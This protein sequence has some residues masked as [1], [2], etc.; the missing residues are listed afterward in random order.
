[1]MGCAGGAPPAADDI[2]GGGT[3]RG[4]E[5]AGDALPLCDGTSRMCVDMP[6]IRS[7]PSS[8]DCGDE[9]SGSSIDVS[10]ARDCRSAEC[11]RAQE[12]EQAE[13]G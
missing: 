5:S 8:G 4:C 9:V 6:T 1:M 7:E 2:C 11:Q 13:C 3:T 10:S 12:I